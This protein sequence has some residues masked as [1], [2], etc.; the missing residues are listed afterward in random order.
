MSED[1]L[2][3]INS[4]IK[5]PVIDYFRSF[6]FVCKTLRN[7]LLLLIL[8]EKIF[9]ALRNDRFAILGKIRRVS[10]KRSPSP[11]STLEQN[12]P[13]A[14]NASGACSALPMF[15][16]QSQPGFMKGGGLGW[17]VLGITHKCQR[18]M[19]LILNPSFSLLLKSLTL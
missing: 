11:S 17:D 15:F 3:F 13:D 14:L 19:C 6:G 2:S 4:S 16:G 18:L 10:N 1:D 12:G 8:D 7:N 9:K 5:V